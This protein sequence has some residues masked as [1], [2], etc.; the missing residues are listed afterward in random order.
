MSLKLK[1]WYA[2]GSEAD[3]AD[4]CAL[5]A[6]ELAKRDVSLQAAV[7]AVIAA[8]DLPETFSPHITPNPAAVVA[9]YAAEHAAFQ[10][11]ADLTGQWPD[12]GALIVAEE[13]I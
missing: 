9:W 6:A 4:A 3:M 8:G 5:A 10:R 13:G 12:H 1:L 11:L 2:A 7:D